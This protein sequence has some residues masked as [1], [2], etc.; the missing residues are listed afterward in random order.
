MELT[1]DNAYCVQTF[2]NCCTACDKAGRKE[3][4][5]FQFIVK[6]TRKT[7]SNEMVVDYY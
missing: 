1:S 6:L 4:A 3:G 7:P 2:G 5:A